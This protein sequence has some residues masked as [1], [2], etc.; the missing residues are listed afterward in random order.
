MMENLRTTDELMQE[1]II[2]FIN[3]MVEQGDRVIEVI[4]DN[5]VVALIV[6]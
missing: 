1:N 4:V 6:S 3:A 5:Y 2:W